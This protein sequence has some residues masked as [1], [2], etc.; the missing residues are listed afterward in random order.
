MKKH[1]EGYVLAFVM[2][3][4]TV[5]CLVAVS[6]MSISLR[7]LEN[8]NAS[9]LRMKDK[10]EAQGVIETV[11]AKISS[12]DSVEKIGDPASSLATY[13]DENGAEI[14][15][16]SAVYETADADAKIKSFTAEVRIEGVSANGSVKV[17]ARLTWSADV[18]EHDGTYRIEPNLLRYLSYQISSVDAGEEGAG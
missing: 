9:I 15:S 16:W 12:S 11:V 7:N 18:T 1:D 13:L 3:V 10:Y 5:L 4:I 14:L 6:L 2:V 8:Q 17:E